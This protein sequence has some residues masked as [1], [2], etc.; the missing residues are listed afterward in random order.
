MK[1]DKILL[2]ASILLLLGKNPAVL[3]AQTLAV[4][5]EWR[6]LVKED[7]GAFFWL[8]DTAWELFHRLNREEADHY[9]RQ[10]AAQGFTVIQAVVLAEFE[11]LS[12]PNPYGHVPLIDNDPT[13]P[14]EDY[15]KHVDYI[16]NKPNYRT[17]F[18]V[19]QKQ[20]VKPVLDGEPNYED[21]PINWQP[22][23]GW[24][25]EFDSRRAGYWSMLSGA[26]GH[27]YG[28]HNIWQFLQPSRVA[29]SSARTPWRQALTYPGAYQAGYM[30]ALFESRSW[31]LLQ[32]DQSLLRSE[33]NTGGK[34]IR[35]ALAAG[36]S[37]AMAYS[38]YGSSFTLSLNGMA[39]QQLRVWW[40]NPRDGTHIDAGF[41]A[42][43]SEVVFDP[44]GDEKRGEVYMPHSSPQPVL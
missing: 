16:V 40:F 23:N 4:S 28:N 5:K 38:P 43:A 3:Q 14:S 32:P 6:H 33:P 31:W 15:L 18:E 25:D 37:L 17:T 20:P 12:Q 10:R 34:E 9:L 8:G 44:P 35:V 26:M 1:C 42:A 27:T 2:C 39:T 19:Y 29:I 30:R 21:H 22:A 13:R 36:G 11:G 41:I 7:G 24:F